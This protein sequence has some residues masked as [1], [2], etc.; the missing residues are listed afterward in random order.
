MS[1]SPHR[2]GSIVLIAREAAG[3]RAEAAMPSVPKIVSDAAETASDCAQRALTT[4]LIIAAERTQPRK[5]RPEAKPTMKTAESPLNGL[6]WVNE[7]VEVM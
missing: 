3:T 6:P 4:I 5:P 1:S 7:T 2:I